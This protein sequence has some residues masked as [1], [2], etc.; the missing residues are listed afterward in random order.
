MTVQM[1]RLSEPANAA[2]HQ[3]MRSMT[4]ETSLAAQL[5]VAIIAVI[6]DQPMIRLIDGRSGR[7][8]P[9]A[10]FRPD[11]SGTERQSSIDECL[12]M[13]VHQDTT[14]E[15][16][17][18][19][20]LLATVTDGSAGA[21]M[22]CI[23]YLALARGSD[24]SNG[25]RASWHSWYDHF[26]W[27]DWRRGQPS[28]LRDGI[29]PALDSWA[30]EEVFADLEP[31]QVPRRHR[32]HLC[33]GDNEQ[34]W[35]EEKVVE[36]FDLLSEAGLI[37][38]GSSNEAIAADHLRCLAVAMSRLRGRIKSRPLV[39]DLMPA[40]FTLYELQRTVEAI[41]GPHLHKQNF[42]RLVE[43]MGLVEPTNE[44][45]SHTGGRP[46][47]LFRFRQACLLEKLQPGLR[48]RGARGG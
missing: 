26:P 44:I 23:G 22:F 17:H 14:L 41:L 13:A 34:M 10:V 9:T 28:T 8:L 21:P 2:R 12:R 27:E 46:A 1:P 25:E 42:R 30:Q 39:F 43:H 33:F 5:I 36:R 40:Q 47:K 24:L 7:H 6:D 20:Q 15:L 45:K 19:E 48:V 18:V 16:G 4:S 11:V 32:I 35:D 3:P 38:R 29:L 37:G 31:S